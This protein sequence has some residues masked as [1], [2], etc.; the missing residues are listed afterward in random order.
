VFAAILDRRH[1][2]TRGGHGCAPRQ[3]RQRRLLVRGMPDFATLVEQVGPAVV[4]V[5]VV[6]RSRARRGA[7]DG[8]FGDEDPFGDFFRRFGLPNQPRDNTPVRGEARD[9]S[10]R[11]MATSSPTRGR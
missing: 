1:R 10:S 9:S 2:G 3:A 11:P 8:P 7:E 5:A 6:G 4:N